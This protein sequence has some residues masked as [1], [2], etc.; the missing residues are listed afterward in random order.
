MP[1]FIFVAG[2]SGSGKTTFANRLKAQIE[3]E[4]SNVSISLL[5]MDNYFLPLPNEI[6]TED[7]IK[8][9]RT[10]T[11]FDVPSQVDFELF[12]HQLREL[13]NNRTINVPVYSFLHSNRMEETNLMQPT[14][15]IIVE[16]IFALHK[17][18]KLAL[19]KSQYISIFIEADSYLTYQNR[20]K[21][22]D[23]QIRDMSVETV[24]VK[25]L[26]HIRD[27]YFSYIRP[28]AQQNAELFISNNHQ[29]SVDSNLADIND[30]F[31]KDIPEVLSKVQDR[32]SD[33]T[34]QS[35]VQDNNSLS[36]YLPYIAW[37]T[38]GLETG[39]LIY[40]MS[41]PLNISIQLALAATILLSGYVLLPNH[42]EQEE[43]EFSSV[44]L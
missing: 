19:N 12:H 42:L 26:K 29:L 28:S 11:N 10:T 18:N 40:A 4:Y 36:S 6:H 17:L 14:D 3:S 7:E 34:W 20:R 9:Y 5:A 32:T 33:L 1:Y 13:A 31:S 35:T 2:S 21:I 38:I 39:L 22:R 8:Q 30:S 44:T 15:I 16:G 25:E 24:Q 23:P 27:S 43:Y 41:I 37:T